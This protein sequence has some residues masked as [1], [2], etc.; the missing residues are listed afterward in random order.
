MLVGMSW[1][2]THRALWF[3]AAA[4]LVAA[5]VALAFRVSNADS[6]LRDDPAACV[7]CH[8]MTPYYAG[9]AHS[10]HRLVATCNDCHVPHENIIKSYAFK[11]MDGAR[12][13]AMFTLRLEPQ[14][15]QLTRISASAVQGNCIRCHEQQVM[16]I[17]MGATPERRC[18]EC[19]RETPH[20][21]VQSLSSAPDA[22]R[23]A[24]PDA[25][26]PRPP[27]PPAGVPR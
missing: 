6:Y 8:I 26:V 20:G 15:L 5:L 10:A 25:G 23:P 2:G 9:W 17:D 4:G 7:N 18:W 13:A 12:H 19:H 22:R 1:G 3:A 27:A 24:L 14:T 16:S 21:L 11:A